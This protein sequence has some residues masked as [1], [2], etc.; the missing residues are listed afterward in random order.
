VRSIHAPLW[1]LA[2]IWIAG[3]VLSGWSPHDR[4][5]WFAEVAPALIVLPLLL[6]TANRFEFST[7]A[8]WLILLHGLVLM[9]GGAYTYARVPAGYWVQ[10]W[11]HLA[12]NPYDKLG[13]F[14][15]GLVPAIVAR[16][17]L[18]RQFRQKRGWLLCFLV[19]AICLAISAFYEM[20]EWWTALAAGG[21]ATDFLGTQGDPW[22]TQED[23][24]YAL[25]GAITALLAFSRLHDRSMAEVEGRR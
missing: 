11:F 23:M 19:V 2:G 16:E 10:D 25:I 8:Y 13:H 17:L 22:D 5:T 20:I 21:G 14:A 15:Q 12:R 3:L 9:G 6:G 18:I 24:F 4:F 1:T 7:L